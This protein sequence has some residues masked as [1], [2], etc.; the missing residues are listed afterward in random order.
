ML[1][2]HNAVNEMACFLKS[3]LLLQEQHKNSDT[4][5]AFGD[6]GNLIAELAVSAIIGDIAQTSRQAE[7]LKEICSCFEV[8]K[9]VSNST[10]LAVLEE[11]GV[12]VALPVAWTL[13]FY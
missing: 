1:G 2:M 3:I 4:L 12:S 11:K 13:S 7:S 5:H 8:L 6:R 10:L 9:K